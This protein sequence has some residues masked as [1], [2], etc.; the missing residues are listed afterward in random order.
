MTVYS[1]I[2]ICTAVL[3]IA[4]LYY[5]YRIYDIHI[6]IMIMIIINKN[7]NRWSKDITLYYMPL[8][9]RARVLLFRRD[10][11]LRMSKPRASILFSSNFYYN[12]VKMYL[13]FR[14]YY[15]FIG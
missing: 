15:T 14:I 6:I 4:L 2:I 8:W 1:Y 11:S 3:D 7:N 12:I 13:D 10:A 5:V 9:Y